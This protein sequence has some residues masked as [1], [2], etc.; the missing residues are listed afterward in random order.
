MNKNILKQEQKLRRR[1]RVRAKISGTAQRPRL[2]VYRSLK[3]L[4]AQ[5]IDDVA[6]RTLL[7]VSDHEIKAGKTKTDKAKLLGELLYSKAKEKNITQVVFDKGA[8]KYHGRVKA[9]AEGAKEAGLK[10]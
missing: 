9:L 1:K 10:I 2:T 3:H 6:G 7:G 8:Y 4:S 5:L